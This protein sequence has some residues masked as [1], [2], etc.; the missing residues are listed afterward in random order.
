M[1]DVIHAADLFCGAGGTSSGL[2]GAAGAL[3]LTVDLVAVNH[4]ETALQSHRANHPDARHILSDLSSLNPREVM[5]G[6]RLDMLIASP[7]CI[8][9]SNARGARPIKEQLRA[10]A[11]CVLRWGEAL[12]PDKILIENVKEFR[13]WG[14]LG[15][16]GRPLKNRRGETYEAY[17]NA[18]RSLGYRVEDRVLNA[19]DYGD[20]T[21]RQRL[22]IM[23]RR[24]RRRIEWP[25]PTH[26]AN[27]DPTLFNGGLRPWRNARE[28]IDWSIRGQSIFGRKRPLAENTI[29]RISAGLR[30]FGGPA[31]EPFLVMLYGTNDARSISRLLPTVTAGG[32]HIGL[33]EPFILPHPH[34]RNADEVL[35]NT[36]PRSINR[37]L[38]TITASS[39]NYIGLVEPFIT[40]MKG[41][42]KVR[43]V[44]E[45]LPTLTTNPHLYLC[46]PFIVQYNGMSEAHSIEHPLNTITTRDRYG[47]VE[48][49][50]LD[51]LFR[52]LHP[53]ELGAAMSFDR[54]YKFFGTKADVVKQI[55]N[56][57]PRRTAEALCTSLL[58][59]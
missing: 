44:N 43:G 14:P 50:Q 40:I 34:G 16:N 10:S 39:S 7:E 26:S 12:Q 32:N 3:G 29:R 49:Y 37:P 18:L 47:L 13:G 56:A 8:F 1:G 21:T 42:S 45:P 2:Y 4:W 28:I 46:E 38:Q 33:C 36:P 11:W 59:A 48:P 30:K 52:M 41:Q 17:L 15:I 25:E 27:G 24:G 54:G 5:R 20:P 19:A 51:I 35:K 6:K 9:H 23:A 55:G 31:A 22:F 53:Q 58:A 57:V